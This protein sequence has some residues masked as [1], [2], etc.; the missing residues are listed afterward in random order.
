MGKE[1]LATEYWM[2]CIWCGCDMPLKDAHNENTCDW[3]EC[4]DKEVG[5]L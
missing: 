2:D 1:F 5:S 3:Q 4:I